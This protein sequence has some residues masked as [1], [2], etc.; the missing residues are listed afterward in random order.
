MSRSTPQRS[1][2]EH[3]PWRDFKCFDMTHRRAEG[4]A[5]Y[6][7]AMH[8]QARLGAIPVREYSSTWKPWRE[9]DAAEFQ[10]AGI[11]ASP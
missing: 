7:A 2:H 1:R 10:R 8:L 6:A 3:W 9:C 5:L 11:G 4:E